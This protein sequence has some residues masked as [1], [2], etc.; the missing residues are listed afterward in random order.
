[1]WT[2]RDTIN[3]LITPTVDTML[4]A[5]G[6]CIGGLQ[7]IE[8]LGD[9]TPLPVLERG[10]SGTITGAI[11][12]DASGQIATH[13]LRIWIFRDNPAASTF[14]DQLPCSLVAADLTTVQWHL[15]FDEAH[16]ASFATVGGLTVGT[17]KLEVPYEC[18]AEIMR[19]AF[20]SIGTP[21]FAAPT[22]LGLRLMFA[23]D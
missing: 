6:D 11:L 12:Y 14:D 4:Y 1:M 21:T 18:A 8:N 15:I 9:G 17:L 3:K 16:G 13:A 23:R 2:G 5:A 20:E 19:V 7:T 10:G 22:D